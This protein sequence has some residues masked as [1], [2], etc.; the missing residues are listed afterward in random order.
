MKIDSLSWIALLSC[1]L[2]WGSSFVLIKTAGLGLNPYQVAA[3]RLSVAGLCLLPWSVASIRRRGLANI[4]WRNLIIAGATGNFIPYFLFPIAMADSRVSS[5]VAGILNAMTP[6]FA[7]VIGVVFFQTQA[8]WNAYAGIALALSGAL[9]IV[10]FRSSG[11]DAATNAHWAWGLLPLVATALYGWNGNHVKQWLGDYAPIEI[12][13][14]S[15]GLCAI[16]ALAVLLWMPP[17]TSGWPPLVVQSL[18]AA[19]ILGMICTALA[20][21]LIFIL[22]QRTN[23]LFA[24]TVTYFSTIVALG[25]A[26]RQA[27]PLGIPHAVG[28][29]CILGGVW[30]ANASVFRR[31]GN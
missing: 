21:W 13:A 31:W 25:W 10:F 27:E 22:I 5:G 2:I 6:L 18:G 12:A 3:V 30:L 4:Q 24:S 29:G 8:R 14:L 23:V 17:A 7:L 19:A 26:Y 9:V 1:S 11:E 15:L 28:V 20:V 16:P